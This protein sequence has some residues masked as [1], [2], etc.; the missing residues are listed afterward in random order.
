MTRTYLNLVLMLL[1]IINFGCKNDAQTKS[2]HQPTEIDQPQEDADAER[3]S[4]EPG[5]RHLN[6]LIQVEKPQAGDTIET[7]QHIKGKARGV[8]FFEG[9]FPIYLVSEEGEELAVAI[10]VGEGDWMTTEWVEFTATL[11]F[12]PN[13]SGEGFLIFKKDNPSDKR[14]LDREL[15][16]PVSF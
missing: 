7:Q 15:R 16:I 6:D 9:D 8:W 5:E 4:G 10:A 14:E 13:E 3:P 2:E 12:E 11:D 1:L